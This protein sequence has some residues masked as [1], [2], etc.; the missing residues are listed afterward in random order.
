MAKKEADFL[1]EFESSAERLA[2]W[3]GRHA[4]HLGVGLL[5]LIAGVWGLQAWRQ[6]SQ[7][8]EHQASAALAEAERG[9]L[10]AMGVAPGS[11]EVPELAN[12]EAAGRIEAEYRESLANV[13]QAHEGTVAGT[14]A[15][16]RGLELDASGQE[17]EESLAALRALHDGLSGRATELRPLLLQRIAQAQ[18]AAGKLAEAAE[19]YEAIG[20]AADYPPRDFALADAAR[21]RAQAGQPQRALALYERLEA[22]SPEFRLPD[23]HRLLLQE[24]RAAPQG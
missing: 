18:E 19:S 13:A 7:D 1:D 9:Y 2:D 5:V 11:P 16:L 23:P 12:P 15:R 3:V 14:L 20:E 21:C 10:V 24:L 6:G 22:R 8:R 17:P 4:V